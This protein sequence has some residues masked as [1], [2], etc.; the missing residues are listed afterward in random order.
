VFL[1]YLILR[2]RVID[3][4]FQQNVGYWQVDLEVLDHLGG[5]DYGELLVNYLGRRRNSL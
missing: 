2:E 5:S 1:P 4:L 3:R